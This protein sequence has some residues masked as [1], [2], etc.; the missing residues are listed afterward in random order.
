MENK[1]S[2]SV[3]KEAKRLL[4]ITA[5][6]CIMAVNIKSFYPRRESGA[7]RL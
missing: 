5:G 4:M 1:I 2:Q 6:A 3:L 7:G